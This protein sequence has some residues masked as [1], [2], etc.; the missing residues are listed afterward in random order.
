[1][2][3]RALMC[4]YCCCL[5][6]PTD[7]IP[8]PCPHQ[9]RTKSMY[10][11]TGVVP[12]F[13]K[14]L[15][16][17]PFRCGDS[18]CAARRCWHAQG[19]PQQAPW[20]HFLAD[21]STRNW[22]PLEACPPPLCLHH[23]TP[24]RP[25]AYV[26]VWPPRRCLWAPACQRMESWT[27]AAWRW[28]PPWFSPRAASREQGQEGQGQEGAAAGGVAACCI[29]VLGSIAEVDGNSWGFDPPPMPAEA[30]KPTL[31]LLTMPW[32]CL[33][34]NPLQTV[35]L[36]C[37]PCSADMCLWT[38]SSRSAPRPTSPTCSSCAR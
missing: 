36:S 26:R 16:E 1:M 4:R 6:T 37:H 7:P 31:S 28:C 11:P 23:P 10:L 12:M 8:P 30:I 38:R 9:A 25:A 21:P 14:S 17:G 19:W 27:W 24:H 5:T 13:P 32:R 29:K 3:L 18:G 22:S 15:A 20:L 2:A 33:P 35:S 34:T